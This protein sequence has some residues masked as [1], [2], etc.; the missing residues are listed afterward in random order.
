M[1]QFLNCDRGVMS[2]KFIRDL[3]FRYAKYKLTYK[4]PNSF[5]LIYCGQISFSAWKRNVI[6]QSLFNERRKKLKYN[7]HN[8][9]DRT[10]FDKSKMNHKIEKIK[11][12]NF[13]SAREY[14]GTLTSYRFVLVRKVSEL[15]MILILELLFYI[16]L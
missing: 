14:K 12:I 7:E 10:A 9:I 3:H 8:M 11:D 1:A 6:I 16:D 2:L 4:F 5:G 13:L 15:L